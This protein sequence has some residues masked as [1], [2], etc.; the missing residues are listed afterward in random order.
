VSEKLLLMGVGNAA[1]AINRCAAAS[2]G[3]IYGTT[4]QAAKMQILEEVGINPV[5]CDLQ[6]RESLA[7]IHEIAANAHVVVSFPPDEVFDALLSQTVSRAAKIVY[8]S[9]TGVYGGISGIIDEATPVDSENPATTARLRAEQHWRAQGATVLRAPALYDSN[10]GLHIS[11]ITGKFRL[12]GDGSRY[13]SRIHLDDL[14]TIVIKALVLAK[15]GSTY[16]VG[17]KTPAPQIEVVRWLCERLELEMPP[18]IPIEQAHI[19]Q[20]GNRQIK[21]DKI[22]NDLNVSLKFPSYQDGFEHCIAEYMA[23]KNV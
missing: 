8:I 5:L 12:P 22:L 10:Y 23:A 2:C 18:S 21:S 4:R 20:Q 17:D 11:L 1:R 3:T 9:S 13:S 14:A 6:S 16:V 7:A 19:T 15:N